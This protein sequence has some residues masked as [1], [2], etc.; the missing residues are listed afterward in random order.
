MAAEPTSSRPCFQ[1]SLRTLLIGVTLF[2]VLVGSYVGWQAKIVRERKSELNRVAKTYLIGVEESDQARTI[3]WLR[4]LLGDV[5]VDFI[6]V[7]AETPRDEI[8]R[9]HALFPESR[10]TAGGGLDSPQ[11]R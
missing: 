9:L 2:C 11:V 10:V 6:A 4:R 1:F 8:D 5:T 3:P 7:P